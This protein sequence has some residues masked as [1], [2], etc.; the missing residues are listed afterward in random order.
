M[1]WQSFFG[2]ER[3]NWLLQD[4]EIVHRVLEILWESMIFFVKC[5][6]LGIHLTHLRNWNPLDSP[7]ELE[8]TW[9]TWGT[10]IHLTDLRNWNPLDWPEELESTWLT[11]GTGIITKSYRIQQFFLSNWFVHVS[12]L[13][14]LV[15]SIIQLG[16]L[17]Y[18]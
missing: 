13:W 8:S 10:G 9:L 6:V 12:L 5:F 14:A 2:A 4:V 3:Y 15:I 17:L 11:W 18:W 16:Q 7:E 1:K